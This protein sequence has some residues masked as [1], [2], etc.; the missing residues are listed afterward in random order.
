MNPRRRQSRAGFS[1]IEVLVA[2]AVLGIV[3]TI[4]LGTLTTS[5][6]IWRNTEGKVAADREARAAELLMMQD[7]SGVVM[8]ANP[9]LWP[10][11]IT[12][13]G[14]VALRF[15]TTKPQEYQSSGAGNTGDVCFVE[16]TLSPDKDALLRRFLGSAETYNSI[17]SGGAFPPST[18]PSRSQVLATN[19]LANAR[20]AV[21]GM[22]I[23]DEANSTTFVILA[24][25]NPGQSNS[26]LPHPG[27][28]YT[29][30]NPP[31]AVEVN[32]AV[33]DPQEAANRDLLS[34][35]N[36]RLR[37]AG[38]YSFRIVLPEPN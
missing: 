37:N 35:P 14:V 5:L 34:N 36:H 28:V 27:G 24:T 23:A 19:L 10:R 6:G 29:P 38:L 22:A 3:M 12:N 8:P 21:R 30:D 7:L 13:S 1:L 17:I 18:D 33:A 32:F 4:L 9:D 31:V 11:V 15:L 20:D 16:Y 2:S 25:N 26:I